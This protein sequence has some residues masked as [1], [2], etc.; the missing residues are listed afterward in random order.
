[1]RAPALA[2]EQA[3]KKRAEREQGGTGRVYTHSAVQRYCPWCRT[4]CCALAGRY[5]DEISTL[6][7]RGAGR[8]SRLVQRP[9][10]EARHRPGKAASKQHAGIWCFP[11]LARVRV[12]YSSSLWSRGGPRKAQRRAAFSR[13]PLDPHPPI[14]SVPGAQCRPG[15][16]LPVSTSTVYGTQSLHALARIGIQAYQSELAH[17]STRPPASSPHGE[18]PGQAHG[19]ARPG[20][21]AGSKPPKARSRAAPPRGGWMDRCSFDLGCRVR[22]E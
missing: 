8:E 5:L 3:Y 13:S 10:K 11:V 14:R 7:S 1:M 6:T 9:T 20:S 16:P 2:R 19:T 22:S 15:P 4:A 17:P 12:R 18:A 21:K